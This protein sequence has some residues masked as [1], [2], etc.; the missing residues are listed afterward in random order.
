MIDWKNVDTVL[1]DMDGTLLDLHYDNYFWLQHLPKRYAAMH[2]LGEDEARTK[3]IAMFEAARGTLNWYCVDFWSDSLNLD[4]AALKKEIKHLIAIRP[5]A[6]RFLRSL[7]QSYREV[8][9]VTNAHPKSLN[10][11]LD[12]TGIGGFFDEIICSHEFQY[13]KEDQA[14][15]RSLQRKHSFDPTRTLF[16]DD[17]EAVL[18]S[19]K[20]Y[21]VRYLLTLMQPDS[22]LA[23]RELGEHPGFHHFDE[24]MPISLLRGE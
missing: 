12:E 5:H 19:A 1:L 18:S 17:S 14:F 20:Q 15:W 3:L 11:K 2:N 22:Q 23:P 8:L 7:H 24:I 4:I 21:G 16:I 9:L 13:P 10:L 6:E